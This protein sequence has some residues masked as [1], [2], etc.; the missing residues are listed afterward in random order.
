MNKAELKRLAPK[1]DAEIQHIMSTLRLV[2]DGQK[3]TSP[4]RDPVLVYSKPAAK[5]RPGVYI[6]ELHQD[7]PV[8]LK[9]VDVSTEISRLEQEVGRLRLQVETQ[10]RWYRQQLDAH[11]ARVPGSVCIQPNTVT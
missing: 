5:S 1:V 6:P 2:K 9:P 10:E 3:C 4:V 8:S 7:D 11:S